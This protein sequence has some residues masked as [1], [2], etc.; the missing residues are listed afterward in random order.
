MK[1]SFS[2]L[3][4][5]DWSLPQAI[6]LAMRDGYDGLELRFL[7]GEDSF[8]KLPAFQGTGLKHTRRLISESGLAIT[9]LDTACRFDSPDSLERKKWLAEGERMAELAA[10]L[11]APA[12]RVF[13]DRIQ[14]G[15]NRESTSIWVS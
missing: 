12:I 5:P 14:P 7:E 11:G 9:C 8:W 6:D 13:G 4:C 10:R 1:I 3:G 2:T 15:A